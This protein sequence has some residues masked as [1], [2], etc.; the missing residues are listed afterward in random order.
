MDDTSDDIVSVEIRR[1]DFDTKKTTIIKELEG[2]V[3]GSILTDL[4][5]VKCKKINDP[6]RY[7]RSCGPIVVYIT[8][9]NGMCEVMGYSNSAYIDKN[10]EWE[11]QFMYFDKTDFS[12]IV[13]K[14]VDK[15]LVHELI[16]Y[17]SPTT[18]PPTNITES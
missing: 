7:G 14:Y 8:Y 15:T 16:G 6:H 1:L 12:N 4:Q 3:A 5:R 11:L 18:Q 13:C 2:D 10:G 17:L 9:D